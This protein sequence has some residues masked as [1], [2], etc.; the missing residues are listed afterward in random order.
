M[1][2]EQFIKAVEKEQGPLRRFLRTL[3]RGDGA[4]ADDIAQEALLKAYL[5]FEDFNGKSKFSTW[6]YRIAY[7]SF[8][9]WYAATE[10][11]EKYITRLD[12]PSSMKIATETDAQRDYKTLY[13]A[14]D[15]LSEYERTCVLLFYM[16]DRSIAE[17]SNIINMPSGTVKSHLSR[18]RSHLKTKLETLEEWK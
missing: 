18:A 7:N 10:K 1:T 4:T 14:I 8:S 16:E 6:L 15:D 3:C 11:K 12:D 9:D 13:N 17:I 5:H 2:Q